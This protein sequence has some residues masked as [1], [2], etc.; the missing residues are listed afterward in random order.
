MTKTVQ[1]TGQVQYRE[2]DGALLTIRKGPV[3]VEITELDATLG[4]TENESAET[5]GEVH[6]RA[7]LPIADY[8]RYVAEG[9]IREDA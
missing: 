1:V 3:E 8:K 4:W 2:G 5:P 6:N 9:A 7:A